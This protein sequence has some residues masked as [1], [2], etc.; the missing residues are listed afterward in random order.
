MEEIK[1]INIEST[2]ERQQP[3]VKGGVWLATWKEES[4]G[5][6]WFK[7]C[8][9]SKINAVRSALLAIQT[10]TMVN[11]KI[12][13]FVCHYGW[14][15]SK[16]IEGFYEITKVI[17]HDMHIKDKYHTPQD[18]VPGILGNDRN[19]SCATSDS[20]TENFDADCLDHTAYGIAKICA[21]MKIDFRCYK[22]LSKHRPYHQHDEWIKDCDLGASKMYEMCANKFGDILGE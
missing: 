4:T 11:N 7:H 19:L 18:E 21:E 10:Y 1:P 6:S 17:E 15:Y 16:D 14:A 13:S 2:T 22:H 12:P 3:S 20:F 5:M 9:P 8:G